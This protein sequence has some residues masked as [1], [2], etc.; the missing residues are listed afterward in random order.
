MV[1]QPLLAVLLLFG[2]GAWGQIKDPG[3]ASS[4]DCQ[5]WLSYMQMD[6]AGG[7]RGV[8][9]VINERVYEKFHQVATDD[10]HGGFYAG[11]WRAC[12][13][14][15]AG[16]GARSDHESGSSRRAE[17]SV[18]LADVF[19]KLHGPTAQSSETADAAKCCRTRAAM[20]FPNRCSWRGRARD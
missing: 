2:R 1:G 15:A 6:C 5:E 14:G 20:D 3:A 13:R 18:A 19:G 12:I 8:R 10:F 7:R 9:C 16:A 4:E 17:K 11:G